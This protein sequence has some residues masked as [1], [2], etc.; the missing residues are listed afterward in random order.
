MSLTSTLNNVTTN[1]A[2]KLEYTRSFTGFYHFR[3]AAPLSLTFELKGKS[4]DDITLP[5]AIERF[6]LHCQ[7]VNYR[8]IKVRPFIVDLDEREARINQGDL[9]YGDEL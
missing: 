1:A 9:V 8:F 7:R 2:G 5:K 4:P 3:A 6:K